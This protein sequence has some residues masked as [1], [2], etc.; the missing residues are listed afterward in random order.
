MNVLGKR[1]HEDEDDAEKPD[2]KCIKLSE[3]ERNARFAALCT[4]RRQHIL[5]K[6]LN[7]LSDQDLNL[8]ES[9]NSSCTD[10]EKIK[11]AIKL[12][13]KFKL[14]V[15]LGDDHND[16]SYYIENGLRRVYP[17]HYLYQSYAKRRWVGRKL[18]D[19]IT[20]EF[21]D[22][23][24]DK[25]KWRFD[26]EKILINGDPIGFDYVLKDNDNIANR[27]H[28]HELPVLATPI[29]L[30]YE[31][32]D[33]IVI[34]KPPSIPIH[35]CGRYRHNSVLGILR[36]EHNIHMPKVVHRLDRLVSGV[37]LLAKTTARAHF[38]EESIKNREVEKVYVCRVAGEFPLGDHA[39][40]GEITVNQPLETIPGKIG[41][42]VVLDGA[43][44]STTIF[45]RLNYNGKTSAVLCRPKTGRMHQIRVHLQY[46]GY[47]IVN[48][49]LY[50]CPSFGP[51]RGKGGRYGKSL[52]Q[53]S[54]D[55]VLM[56]RA[57][58]WL[59]DEH[60][61]ITDL[62][63]DGPSEK[64][65]QADTDTKSD[66]TIQFT[67]DSEREETMAALS[68]YFTNESWKDLEEKWK[69]DPAKYVKDPTCRDCSDEFH[70]PPP[71]SLYLY[72]HALKYSG[73]G[74]S[75]ES[76]MPVWAKDSWQY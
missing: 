6:V 31:D 76:E 20:S 10:V 66:K 5:T 74:W 28:R 52:K 23:S 50:N 4:D 26:K 41:I 34:D 69:F 1:E 29:K 54:A 7:K 60:A 62:P 65:T 42:T 17:Y 36:A 68:H 40:D 12:R 63:D 24:Q 21:R 15:R 51:E 57:N 61:D 30:I 58:T 13:T 44:S 55:V 73:A 35:T 45:K 70:D 33:T 43:K 46:L 38:L 56:H 18:R 27:V 2:Q 72:L 11:T 75:Y 3:D 16:S 25:L 48:D 47:P 49:N 71:R 14:S 53:L 8:L 32:K 59:I 37:L 22:I 64:R 9:V 67:S 19:V 39:D